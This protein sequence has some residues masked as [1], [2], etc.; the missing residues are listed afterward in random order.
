MWKRFKTLMLREWM[1]H[2]RGWLI[3]MLAPPLIFLALLP[4]GQVD[5]EESIHPLLLADLT[6]TISAVLVSGIAWLALVLQL[7]GLARRDQQDRSIEFWRS[8]PASHSESIGALLSMHVFVVPVLALLLGCLLGLPIAIGLV[9]K[10]GG[11]AALAEIAWPVLLGSA[12]AGLARLVLGTV[13]MALW[14]SPLLMLLMAAS[15]WLKRLGVPVVLGVIGVGGLVLDKVYGLPVVWV[16]LKAQI[17]GALGAY[18]NHQGE[19]DHLRHDPQDLLSAVS[20]WAWN[21]S[22]AALGGLAS[23]HL[24]GGLLLAGLCFWLLVLKRQ[25]SG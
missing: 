12:L 8:L 1:Q 13:L 2:H 6:L 18:L 21:D 4:V 10:L 17:Q 25:R 22:L 15:A 16:L 19:F 7:P 11:S 9:F 20:Q 24:L 23:P 3:L 14:L 5:L